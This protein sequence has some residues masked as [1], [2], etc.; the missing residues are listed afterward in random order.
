MTFP[1]PIQ[2]SSERVL[3]FDQLRQLARHLYRFAAWT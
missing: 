3:E 2:H 1:S